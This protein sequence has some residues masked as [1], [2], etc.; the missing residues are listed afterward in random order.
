MKAII[1]KAVMAVV[2]LVGLLLMVGEMPD[3]CIGE[4]VAYKAGGVLLL[5]LSARVMERFIPEEEV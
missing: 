3:A 2:A 4:L 5:L 1:I